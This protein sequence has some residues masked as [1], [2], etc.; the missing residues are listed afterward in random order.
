MSNNLKKSNHFEESNVEHFFLFLISAY[1]DLST[2]LPLPP[3]LTLS[4]VYLIP[5]SHF[6]SLPASPLHLTLS[7]FLPLPP[8][9]TLSPF[10]PLPPHLTLSSFLPLSPH[11][12]SLLS[13]LSPPQSSPHFISLFSL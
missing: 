8:H 6:I 13:S 2:F 4:P 12:I 3:H 11:I 5:S 10:L 7:P 9:L 1:S